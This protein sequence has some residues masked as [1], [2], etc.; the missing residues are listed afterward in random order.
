MDRRLGNKERGGTLITKNSKE[1]PP[2]KTHFRE[3]FGGGVIKVETI[4]GL[5]SHGCF[6][7]FTLCE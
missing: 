1:H 2:L 3:I 7:R 4:K 5:G 6:R